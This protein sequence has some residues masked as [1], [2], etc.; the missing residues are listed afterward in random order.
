MK[1]SIKTLF[2]LGV[3][4]DAVKYTDLRFKL[5]DQVKRIMAQ[6]TLTFALIKSF[7]LCFNKHLDREG[8]LVR[9][10]WGEPD[11]FEEG[12]FNPNFDGSVD[13]V[14]MLKFDCGGNIGIE[15][16]AHMRAH[17]LVEEEK[18]KWTC[19]QTNESVQVAYPTAPVEI[20]YTAIYPLLD[21][22]L[23][24]AA[25]AALRDI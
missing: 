4:M 11:H 10:G 14:L 15:A 21:S 8:K 9:V 2:S 20:S 17:L 13:F 24:Q 19:I 5:S 18:V 7:A 12:E 23:E 3:Q 22:A 1:G 6:R 25:F 16:G